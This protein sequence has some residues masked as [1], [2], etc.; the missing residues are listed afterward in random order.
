M[1]AMVHFFTRALTWMRTFNPR[2]KM[3][4]GL[5]FIAL[6]LLALITPLT[7][8]SWLV[9]IGLE[10]IGIRILAWRRLAQWLREWRGNRDL[11]GE[12]EDERLP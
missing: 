2:L 1:R 6:G 5:F 9:F 3:L 8:G 7:P 12:G 11:K 10:F 4:I